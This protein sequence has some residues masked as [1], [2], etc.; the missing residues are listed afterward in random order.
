VDIELNGQPVELNVAASG[1]VSR[2]KINQMNLESF[3]ESERTSPEPDLSL[4]TPEETTTDEEAQ[5]EST[6]GQLDG[7]R[8]VTMFGSND[9]GRTDVAKHV[10]RAEGSPTL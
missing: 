3:F 10:S 8:K 6:I 9:A 7:W 5:P 1:R 2:V 4:P